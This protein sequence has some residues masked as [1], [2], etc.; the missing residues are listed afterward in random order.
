MFSFN[1]WSGVPTP[2][3]RNATHWFWLLNANEQQ[4]IIDHLKTTPRSV[5]ITYPGLDTFLIDKLHMR[6]AGPL[7][8]HIHSHFRPLFSLSGYEFLV[9]LGSLAQPFLIA[10]NSTRRAEAGPGETSLISVNV[11]ARAII[12]RVVV[13]HVSDI[14]HDIR[15]LNPTNCQVSA[16][17]I[18]ALGQALGPAE[19]MAWPL[20]LAGLYRLRL[21]HH[22]PD[23]PAAPGYQLIFL[24]A[25]G[26]TR[27]EA[28]YNQPPTASAPPAGG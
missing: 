19:P 4:G 21:Y 15:E 17:P 24:D 18:N 12:D 1:L 23:F 5:I 25:A 2:T 9:P 8:D 16:E 7:V 28:G 20:R 13:R 11:V 22:A 3:L 6:I 14:R 26:Q 27:L 10:E